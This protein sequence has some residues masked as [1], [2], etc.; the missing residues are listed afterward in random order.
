MMIKTDPRETGWGGTDGINLVH[1]WDQLMALMNT[2]M[3]L[4]VP[5]NFETFLSNCTTGGF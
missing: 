5:Q 4:R 2:V 1:D 3:K